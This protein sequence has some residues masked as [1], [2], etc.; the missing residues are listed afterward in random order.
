MKMN[1]RKKERE[2][3]REREGEGEIEAKEKAK[4]KEEKKNREEISTCGIRIR[5]NFWCQVSAWLCALA[6]FSMLSISFISSKAIR[7]GE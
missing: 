6:K 5:A 7:A 4:E 1:K 2:R 3:E